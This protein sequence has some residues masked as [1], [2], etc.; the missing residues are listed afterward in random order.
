MEFLFK[1]TI[2]LGLTCSL[3]HSMGLENGNST[4]ENQTTPTPQNQT[5]SPSS[6]ML[7][8]PQNLRNQS[9][10]NA[11]AVFWDAVDGATEYY[12]SLKQLKFLYKFSKIILF[13]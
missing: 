8:A 12:V 6:V 4:H 9:V 2:I 3:S 1:I 13:N 10:H 5:D 11:I 7:G